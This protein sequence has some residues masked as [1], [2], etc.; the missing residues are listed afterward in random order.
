VSVCKRKL[1][2]ILIF[3]CITV[4]PKGKDLSEMIIG[5]RRLTFVKIKLIIYG[6]AA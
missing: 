3:Y 4:K 1:F 2:H 5:K 6:W